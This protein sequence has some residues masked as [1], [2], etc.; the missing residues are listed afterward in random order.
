MFFVGYFCGCFCFFVFLPNFISKI[1]YVGLFDILEEAR[2]KSL[3]IAAVSNAPKLNAHFLID[4]LQL[5]PYFEEIIIGEDCE[6]G[7]P[8]PM[9]Y[10]IAMD[11]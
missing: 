2:R 5:R 11:R 10:L 7:K 4:H 8:H 1:S 9:P 6:R 3:R